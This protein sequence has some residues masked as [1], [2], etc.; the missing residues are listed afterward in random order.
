MQ[1]V[2]IIGS[3]GSGKSTL[4]REIGART[5]LPVVHLDRHYW[6]PG[7]VEPSKETWEAQVR[8]LVSEPA[9]VMDGNYGGTFHLRFPEADTIVF[10]NRSRWLCLWRVL[11]R[12]IRFH[13]QSRPD[14]A[15]GCPEHMTLQF[16]HYVLM[17]P[18][19]RRPGILARL[20][21]VEGEKRIAILRSSADVTR[22]LD[23]L[24]ARP[25]HPTSGPQR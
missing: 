16:L 9:W 12:R 6:R 1:R 10:L 23:G 4:A 15:E 2:L 5:G 24:D 22:F 18:R 11:A 7:W 17:Y 20:R 21:N 19:T 13:R 3:G 25:S 8:D 14:M